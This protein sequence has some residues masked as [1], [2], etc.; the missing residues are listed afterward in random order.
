MTRAEALAEV[1][2]CARLAVDP[3]GWEAPEYSMLILKHALEDLDRT[4]SESDHE[5]IILSPDRLT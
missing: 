1:V 5:D 4:G 3:P 2:R